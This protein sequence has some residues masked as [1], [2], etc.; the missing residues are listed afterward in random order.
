M[1]QAL[2]KEKQQREQKLNSEINGERTKLNKQK[3]QNLKQETA[4]KT[5]KAGGEGTLQ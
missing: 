2:E 4:L 3:E 5:K 1:K